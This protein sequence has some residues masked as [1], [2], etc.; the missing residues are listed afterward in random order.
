MAKFKV[1]SCI[2]NNN[3]N[4]FIAVDYVRCIVAIF[5]LNIEPFSWKLIFT[6]LFVSV[7]IVLFQPYMCSKWYWKMLHWMMTFIEIQPILFICTECVCVCRY[8]CIVCH[9]Y[10]NDTLR[11]FTINI[12][13]VCRRD[14]WDARSRHDTY[15]KAEN[16]S[17]LSGSTEQWEEKNAKR[18]Q[19]RLKPKRQQHKYNAQTTA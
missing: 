16:C 19:R 7:F 15:L 18:Q 8:F 10:L 1:K 5:I 12:Q 14:K 11:T 13:F 6:F 3:N 2:G 9:R 4:R 17:F